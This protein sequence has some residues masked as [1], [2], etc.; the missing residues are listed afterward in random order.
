MSLGD[1]RV[2]DRIALLKE[3]SQLNKKALNF[4]VCEFGGVLRDAGIRAIPIYAHVQSDNT[5]PRNSDRVYTRGRR[6]LERFSV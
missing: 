4:L 3:Y 2:L 1:S 6:T 5:N